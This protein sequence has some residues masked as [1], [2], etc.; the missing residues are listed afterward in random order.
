MNRGVDIEAIYISPCPDAV[1]LSQ[2]L[3]DAASDKNYSSLNSV[4][5]LLMDSLCEW[6]I[7]GERCI[8]YTELQRAS[9]AAT[10]CRI[11]YDT[12]FNECALTDQ[13]SRA[14]PQAHVM[15]FNLQEQVDFTFRILQNES[16]LFEYSNAPGAFNWG[17]CIGKG[18][19]VQLGQ[20]DLAVLAE[21]C[22]GK[23]DAARL[24]ACF[25]VFKTRCIGENVAK[26]KYANGVYDSVQDLAAALGVP[27][28][29]RFFQ[30]WLRS[31]LDWDEDNVENVLVFRKND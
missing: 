13:I 17:R 9:G 21:A 7:S 18:E 25:D 15:Q 6:I 22:G 3:V 27:K 29:Y 10:E 28:L 30:G 19:A 5:D 8:A 11:V 2:A 14:L 20:V 26:G 31:D 24:A 1:A 12:T 4:D 23:P 16:V